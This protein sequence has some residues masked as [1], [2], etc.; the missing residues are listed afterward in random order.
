[1]IA[2]HSR[3][4]A[5]NAI[6]FIGLGLW[7][8]LYPSVIEEFY[9]ITLDGPMALSEM[10]AV[11]GGMMAGIGVGVL[12][13]VRRDVLTGGVVMICV[14]GGLLLARIVGLAAEGVPTGAVLNETIFELVFFVLMVG[15]GI[16]ARR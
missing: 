12:W 11:F 1:M 15:T 13:L 10:R 9:P 4:V 2:V 16:F 3:L 14:F 6:L 8:M 5:L 7:L